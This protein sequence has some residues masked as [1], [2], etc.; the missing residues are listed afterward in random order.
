MSKHNKTSIT[1]LWNKFMESDILPVIW[2]TMII[3]TITAAITSVGIV[4]IRWLLTLVGVI[5]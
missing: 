4:A 5:V 3:L 2:G 1:K